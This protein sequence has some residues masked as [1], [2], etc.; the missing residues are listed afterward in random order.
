[1][2]T[3]RLI[4][5]GIMLST[6]M[7]CAA[8]K[9]TAVKAITFTQLIHT[10]KTQGCDAL[11]EPVKESFVR[12][13]KTRLEHYPENGICNPE[14]VRDVLL[15]Q[16]DKLEATNVIHNGSSQL[17]YSADRGNGSLDYP[18]RAALFLGAFRQ[19]NCCTSGL[20]NRFGVDSKRGAFV[21]ASSIEAYSSSGSRSRLHLHRSLQRDNQSTS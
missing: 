7:A 16:I 11:S 21:Y 8:V 12:L 1:M 14:W 3:M 15:K 13:I 19:G 10:L 2:K 4:V 17:G 20:Q 9:E 6:L 18:N 5:V